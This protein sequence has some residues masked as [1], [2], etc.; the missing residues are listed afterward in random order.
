MVVRLTRERAAA[1]Q[2]FAATFTIEKN[3]PL[4]VFQRMMGLMASDSTVLRLG[5][6]HMRPF[7]LWL[8]RRVPARVWMSGLLRLTVNQTCAAALK[9]WMRTGWYQTGVNLGAASQI[10]VVST[11]ASNTGWGAP[12]QRE[13]LHGLV[14]RRREASTHKLS[15]DER[16]RKR[17]SVLPP[18]VKEPPRSGPG[19]RPRAVGPTCVGDQLSSFHLPEGVLNTITQ[20]RAPSTRRLY[21]SKWSVFAEWCSAHD[22]N[23]LDCEVTA[24]LSFLLELLDNGSTP[25]TIKVYVAAIAA[26][27]KPVNGQSLGKNDLVIRFLRGARR[28]NRPRA[29]LG[30]SLGPFHGPRGHER[31]TIQTITRGGAN[32]PVLQNRFSAGTS[33]L[34]T[35]VQPARAL[36]ERYVPGICA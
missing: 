22:L 12:L 4:I 14:V 11:D 7:Q 5:L 1:I 30:S 33:L 13:T 8:K 3:L 9:P 34:K 24:V 20:A 21:A 25:S 15:R 32:V 18:R 29:T 26:F 16:G 23:P 35:G 36:S 27:T 17:P 28:L 2:H 6:L 10:K 19:R 31:W